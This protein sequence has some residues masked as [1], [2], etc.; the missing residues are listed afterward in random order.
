MKKLLLSVSALVLS[1]SFTH[2]ANADC[3]GMYLGVRAG[4]TRHD[5]SAKSGGVSMN[6]LKR[7]DKR[8]FM[9]SGALGYRYDYYRTELEYVWRDKNSWDSHYANGSKAND[10]SFRSYSIMWN[11]YIDFAPF[12]WWTPYVGAGIGFTKMN[13]KSTTY[14]DF[15]EVTDNTAG[16]NN[17]PNRFTWSLGGGLSLKVTNR[18]NVDA[19]YRYYDMGSIRWMDVNAHEVYA[20]LRY[21]F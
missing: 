14:N 19:G 11:H 6:S 3:N 8:K 20:G 21:V 5:Y 17:K 1:L 16:W 2:N 9:M 15:G 18:F 7:L 10:L 13:Y 12:N 4:V